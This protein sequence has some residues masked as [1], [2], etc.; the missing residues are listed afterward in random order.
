M[1]D[2][3]KMVTQNHVRGERDRTEH[4]QPQKG[5]KRYTR[6]K[7]NHR[8]EQRDRI[9]YMAATGGRGRLNMELRNHRGTGKENEPGTG[10]TQEEE[11][12][13]NPVQT[14]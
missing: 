10:Q 11:R 1:Q 6:A 3:R 2:A 9:E 12:S 4:M 5:E 7:S 8:K 13:W 14:N